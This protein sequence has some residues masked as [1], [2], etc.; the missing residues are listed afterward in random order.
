MKVSKALV[1]RFVVSMLPH[2]D[3]QRQLLDELGVE[4]SL[5]DNPLD[6]RVSIESLNEAHHRLAEITEDSFVS[7]RFGNLFELDSIGV[8]GLLWRHA[9]NL[10][11]MISLHVKFLGVL[12]DAATAEFITVPDGKRIEWTPML[13]WEAGDPI[14]VQREMEAAIGFFSKAIQVMTGKPLMPLG[15]TMKRDRPDRVPEAFS[16][17]LPITTFNA[18][19]HSI[20]F[21]S[22]DLSTPLISFNPHMLASMEHYVE[23]ILDGLN[24]SSTFAAEVERAILIN[25]PPYL[26]G[27]EQLA[28]RFYMSTRNFQRKLVEEGQSYR[29]LLNRIKTDFA[30]Q[31]LQGGALSISEIGYLLGY[32]EPA[33]FIRFFKKQTGLTPKEFRTR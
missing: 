25:F 4:P 9:S 1:Y 10:D 24:Q 27:I 23:S 2:Q 5:T 20:T 18:D 6:E 19:E 12:F 16:P 15:I 29:D 30:K 21:K 26:P 31:Q 33:A 7:W 3:E 22:V 17:Y 13:S 14:A 28:A 32:T 8:L 11:D